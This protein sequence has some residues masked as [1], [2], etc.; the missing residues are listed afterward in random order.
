MKRVLIL[1]NVKAGHAKIAK[2]LDAIEGVFLDGGYAPLPKPVEFGENPFDGV[3]AASTDMVVVCGGDGTLN[4]AVN[5]M[6]NSGLDI[7]IGIIP[8][9]TANDFAGAIGMKKN[10]VS[11]ARQ[12][13]G[14]EVESIDCGCVNGLYFV[15]VFSFGLFTTTSQHTP[16]AIKH[17]IGKAAYLIEGQKELHRR[18]FI[19]LHVRHD[20]GELDIRS[21]ITLVFNGETAGRFRLARNASLRD[22]LF[23]LLMLDK[24]GTFAAIWAMLLFLINGRENF[25]VRHIRSAHIEMSSPL[26]PP[27]DMDGQRG[28]EFPLVIDC[29]RGG[30]R[31]I[32]PRRG[33]EC[34]GI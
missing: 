3:D 32:C 2:R 13:V 34:R 7:P 18:E 14:G 10:F 4:Y 24:C 25:A 6:K 21:L 9:G 20:G 17:K 1:Y 12:I 8:T 33:G 28:A 5:A 26:S 19:P 16:D 30:I 23:D 31:V 15:N 29:F 27:T 11:A 22:G